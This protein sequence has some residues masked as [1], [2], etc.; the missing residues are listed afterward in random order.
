MNQQENKINV[1]L[2]QSTPVIC[3][4]CGGQVFNEGLYLRKISRFLTGA[5]QDSL[6]PIPVFNCAKCGSVVKELLPD[7]IKELGKE[8]T[9]EETED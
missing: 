1:D 6:V 8:N 7:I 2:R 4:E 3:T 9:K 5:P